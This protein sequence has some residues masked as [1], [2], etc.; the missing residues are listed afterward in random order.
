MFFFTSLYRFFMTLC[1]KTDEK[2]KFIDC[3]YRCQLSLTRNVCHA[4]KHCVW[5]SPILD[6]WRKYCL[7]RRQTSQIAPMSLPIRRPHRITIITY[8]FSE[9][10]FRHTITSEISNPNQVIYWIT[11]RKSSDQR[12]RSKESMSCESEANL[13]KKKN[14]QEFNQSE[15]SVLTI[16]LTCYIWTVMC[17][18]V[19]EKRAE[20]KSKKIKVVNFC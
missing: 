16:G 15:S 7:E 1:L 11:P 6:S 17:M 14:N 20:F 13:K 10:L 4:S 5:P 9:T 3:F 19:V 12:K 2:P 18:C 8:P